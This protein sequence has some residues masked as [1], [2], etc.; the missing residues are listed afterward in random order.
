MSLK[1]WPWL[2]LR[3]GSHAAGEFHLSFGLK[4]L[5]MDVLC[6]Q[7]GEVNLNIVLCLFIISFYPE[8]HLIEAA[9]RPSSQGSCHSFPRD[10]VPPSMV[11]PG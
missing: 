1:A 7:V 2:G 9:S 6:F 3:L 10:P 5:S 11:Q 8:R 4:L